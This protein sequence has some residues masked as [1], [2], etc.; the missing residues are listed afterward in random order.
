MRPSVELTGRRESPDAPT[1][2]ALS[3]WLVAFVVAIGHAD[4]ALPIP[5]QRGRHRD[6]SAAQRSWVGSPRTLSTRRVTL[7]T[8]LD[9]ALPLEHGADR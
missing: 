7:R 9:T 3:G 6:G 5:A 4:R 1:C 2:A 8:V